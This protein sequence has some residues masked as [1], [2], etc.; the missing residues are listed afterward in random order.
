MVCPCGKSGAKM[1]FLLTLFLS[2]WHAFPALDFDNHDEETLKGATPPY[3]WPIKVMLVNTPKVLNWS[4]TEKKERNKLFG[5]HTW[6]FARQNF[7]ICFYSCQNV[8]LTRSAL[9]RFS[10]VRKSLVFCGHCHIS[11]LM[12]FTSWKHEF[13]EFLWK[14]MERG[15]Y[16]QQPKFIRLQTINGDCTKKPKK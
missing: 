3:L 2:S 7:S 6:I 14:Q 12:Y 10:T 9:P 16:W 15:V 1:R 5:L 13:L 4:G 8:W 11:L